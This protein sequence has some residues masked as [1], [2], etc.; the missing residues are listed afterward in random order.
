MADQ[1]TR[2]KIGLLDN[3]SH[4]LQRGYEMWSKWKETEDAWLLKE[5]VI[6]V[7][8]GVELALKQLLVQTNEFLVFQDVDKAVQSLEKLRKTRGNENAGVLDL[9]KS[10]AG[11]KS[12]NFST[13][14]NRVATM[15]SISELKAKAPLRDNIDKLAS[16]RN[17][18]VHFSIELDVV[19][20][21][22]MLSEILNPL[23]NLLSREIK[24][25]SFKTKDISKI[26][27]FAQPLQD[28]VKHIRADIVESAIKSTLRALPPRGNGKAGIVWQALGSG[29]SSSL[30]E[31]VEQLINLDKL[32]DKLIIIFVD[33]L[34]LLHQ[35]SSFFSQ[36]SDLDILVPNTK[37]QL[38]AMMS[39]SD[40]CRVVISTIQKLEAPVSNNGGHFIFIGFGLHSGDYSRDLLSQFSNA[41][42]IL[43]SSN[44]S[45]DLDVKL[46]GS[47]VASYSLRQAMN[48]KLALP[49]NIEVQNLK[50]LNGYDESITREAE[51]TPFAE[52]IDRAIEL[53]PF[54][55]SIIEHF[56]A[57]QKRWAG[58]GV[59]V[60]KDSETATDLLKT[61]CQIRP[62]W[63]VASREHIQHISS[64][65]NLS[66]KTTCLHR[67]R[68]RTDPLVLLIGN[69][70]FLSAY[71]N[72][73]IHTVYLIDLVSRQLQHKLV[74][75]VTR[76]CEG[77]RDGVIVDYVGMSDW[78]L[79]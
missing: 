76:S 40:S 79:D 59:I 68:D 13:V 37:E 36:E 51:L 28:Y 2:L 23:L 8:H 61:I 48:D 32:R 35:V 17:S 52:S 67:F 54:A 70:N 24:D 47:I 19:E 65:S 71:D 66:Q 30:L 44:V 41:T 42:Y 53:T 26:S 64:F 62:D 25:E 7:H 20:V 14:V 58:K 11:A 29:L 73:W 18:M 49:L 22:S 34:A 46:F 27:G 60:T 9:F 31:Y 45:D 55:E 10:R 78:K 12:A 43:F 33:R 69:G 5:S 63:C 77:K 72:P 15:L 21:S 4:S 16:Y 50:I 75:V 3:S 38:K 1:T 39:N 74:S 56:T 6:W 57:R